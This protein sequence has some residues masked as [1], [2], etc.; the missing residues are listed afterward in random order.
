MF[1]LVVRVQMFD[2]LVAL[3]DIDTA[4]LYRDRNAIRYDYLDILRNAGFIYNFIGK[5]DRDNPFNMPCPSNERTQSP[6]P[7]SRKVE[8][9]VKYASI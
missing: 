3:C 7:I 2:K 6:A 8:F 5:I 1:S 4:L 9:G